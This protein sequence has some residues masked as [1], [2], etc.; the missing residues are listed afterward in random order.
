MFLTARTALQLSAY[1][2]QLPEEN[3]VRA[4]AGLIGACL[5]IAPGIVKCYFEL[6]AG[7]DNFEWA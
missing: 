5:K 4:K 6:G 3:R 2:F 1:K 7:K